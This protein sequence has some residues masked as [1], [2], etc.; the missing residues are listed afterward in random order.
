MTDYAFLRTANVQ[1]GPGDFRQNRAQEESTWAKQRYRK[2][3]PV[4]DCSKRRI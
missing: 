3:A 2:G 4:D 1:V